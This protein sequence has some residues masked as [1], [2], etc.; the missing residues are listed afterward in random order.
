MQERHGIPFVKMHGLGNDFVIIDA[1][2]RAISLSETSLR[3]LAD[4]RRGVGCDQVLIIDPPAD[5]GVAAGMRIYNADG[6][7]AQACGNGTRC[8]AS[9]LMD[10]AGADSLVICTVAGPLA[11]TRADGIVTA[12]MG[13]TRGGWDEIPLAKPADTDRLD[14]AEGPLS[15]PVAVNI[16]NPH[17]VFFVEDAEAVD[18]AT[19]GPVL[20]RH[21]MLPERANIEVVQVLAPDRLRMRVWERG[22]GITQ[23]CGTGACAAVVAAHRRGLIGRKATVFLDGGTLDI[24]FREDGHVLMSGPTALSFTGT[25][26]PEAG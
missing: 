22:D 2:A 6:S 26:A 18:L 14:I 8:V 21:P 5:G 1:R 23:A 25:F 11:C 9:L 3:T 12:D 20:E 13:P 4:R 10:E 19:H 24:E 15:G 7:P 17:L 16:G